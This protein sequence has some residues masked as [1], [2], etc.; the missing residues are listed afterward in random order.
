M[1]PTV[2]RCSGSMGN[3]PS[4]GIRPWV[5]FNPTI[6]QQAAGTRIEPAVSVPNATS[7]CP[8]ET[9]TAEPHEEPPGISFQ[10]LLY[11]LAGVPK[12]SLVPEGEMA[13]SLRLVLPTMW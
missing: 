6:P 1:G 11:G 2:S 10:S 3:T 13:N 8:L 7:A 12:Y 5:V 4:S 9:A